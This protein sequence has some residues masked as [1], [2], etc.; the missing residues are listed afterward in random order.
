MSDERTCGGADFRAQTFDAPRRM[1]NPVPVVSLAL[2]AEAIR[3]RSLIAS[4]VAAISLNSSIS[5]N[6][7][8]VGCR[9]SC[10]FS[11]TILSRSG[12]TL[13]SMPSVID[14][15]IQGSS[16]SRKKTAC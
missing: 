10:E 5:S 14:R 2:N 3:S 4:W 9:S 6:W 8:A 16:A 13:G 12:I 15:R 7:P 1:A 11:Q